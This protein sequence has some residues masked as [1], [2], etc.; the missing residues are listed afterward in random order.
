MIGDSLA[1]VTAGYPPVRPVYAVRPG[2]RGDLTLPKGESASK[3]VAWSHQRGGTY[4]P[5]PILYRGILYTCNNNGILTAYR[6][7]TGEQ[8]SIIRLSPTTAS[9][10]ASPVAADG[11]LY[12]ASETGDVYILR[13]GPEPEP[14]NG[15][16]KGYVA[17]TLPAKPAQVSTRSQSGQ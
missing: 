3:A 13:A 10:S 9:F 15:L 7:E 2:Q 16:K 12:F 4:I 17:F 14:P 11:K 1:F 8:L 5:S 6:A